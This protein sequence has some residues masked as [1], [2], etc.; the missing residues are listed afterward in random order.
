VFGRGCEFESITNGKLA[1][2]LEKEAKELQEKPLKSTIAK[3]EN[4]LIDGKSN[5]CDPEVV[6]NDGKNPKNKL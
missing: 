2:Q 6:N 1:S 4:H 3:V 5:N